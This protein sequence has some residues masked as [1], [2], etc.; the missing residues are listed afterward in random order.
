MSF[1]SDT[2]REL[3][4]LEVSKPCC[5]IAQVYALLLFSHLLSRR[6]AVYRTKHEYIARYMT[7]QIAAFCAVPVQFTTP[8][9]VEGR[10]L[11]SVAVPEESHRIQILRQFGYTGSEPGL[12]INMDYLKDDCCRRAFL[13]GAFLA[14][15]TVTDPCSDYH[16]QFSTQHKL[17]SDDFL[18]LLRS[19]NFRP[20]SIERSG[21]RIVYL[22]NGEDI[23]EVLQQIGTSLAYMEVMG[24]RIKRDQS[25]KVQR[26]VNFENANIRKTANAAA[27]QIIAIRKIAETVGIDALP[28]DLREL[29]R[30]R[31][32]NPEMT[33]RDLGQALSEPISRSGVNHRLRRIVE[34]SQTI[35]SKDKDIV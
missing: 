19:M 16:M 24:Q 18:S 8:E 32:E 6:A 33:L 30:V 10:R 25:N 7:E 17:L 29:A 12:R 14:C 3:C 1:S 5:A 15:G 31:Y 27:A 13:R 26:V 4:Q 11:Y 20:G 2:K 28:E 23:E 9:R 35:G 22:K 21:S 34:F